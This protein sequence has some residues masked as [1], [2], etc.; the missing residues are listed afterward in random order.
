MIPGI[1]LR[2]LA[3]AEGWALHETSWGD[4]FTKGTEMHFAPLV[5]RKGSMTKAE[6]YPLFQRILDEFGFIT[7][8]VP[9]GM[10]DRFTRRIGFEKTWADDT[11]TYYMLDHM[12]FRK[13]S[14]CQQHL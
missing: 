11:Y 14:E 12:P 6:F 8:R 9:H 10:S 5:G 2:A 1:P 13:E 4:I 7:T 3:E